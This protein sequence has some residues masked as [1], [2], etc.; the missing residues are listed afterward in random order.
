MRRHVTRMFLAAA[1]AGVTITASG[2]VAAGT[3][4]AA[5]A[6]QRIYTNA[7]AGYFAQGNGQ[8]FQRIETSLKVPPRQP[9]AGNS[10]LAE[11]SL[12]GGRTHAEAILVLPG[13]G[14]GSVS[15]ATARGVK[16]FALSPRAGDTLKLSI[17]Y[18]Q[19]THRDRFAVTDTRTHQTAAVTLATGGKVNYTQASFDATIQNSK[20]RNPAHDIQLWAFSNSGL[21]N[22]SGHR[23]TI[24]GPHGTFEV[25]DTTT[26]T[27][28]GK[29]VMSPSSLR[30]G[31]RDFAIYLRHR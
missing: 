26:G 11:I 8:R 27:S 28:H 9:A 14:R 31:G 19:R 2:L 3:A 16:A 20:V 25:I 17:A 29:V 10:A 4:S 5:T 13:G 21:T 23:Y 22:Y 30:N 15:Y 18:D 12:Y 7:A 24:L 1:A 6:P